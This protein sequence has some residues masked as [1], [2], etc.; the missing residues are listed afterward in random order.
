MADTTLWR[1]WMILPTA[2]IEEAE[3]LG[4]KLLS[5]ATQGEWEVEMSDDTL[6]QIQDRWGGWIWALTPVTK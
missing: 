3:S 6:N 1:G 4:I 5:T 2:C